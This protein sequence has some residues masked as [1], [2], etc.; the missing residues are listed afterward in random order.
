MRGLNYILFLFLVVLASCSTHDEFEMLLKHAKD[1]N[2]EAQYIVGECYENG[3]GVKANMK[4]A[5]Y[6]Y[7]LASNKGYVNATFKLG[8]CYENEIGRAHV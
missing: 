7:E 8:L 4:E 3:D 6:W 5:A 1:G 2:V